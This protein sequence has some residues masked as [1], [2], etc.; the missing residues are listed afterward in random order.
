MPDP[1]LDLV[2]ASAATVRRLLGLDGPADVEPPT[3]DE[4]RRQALAVMG[5]HED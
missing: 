4:L 1:Y 3:S 5:P 2:D